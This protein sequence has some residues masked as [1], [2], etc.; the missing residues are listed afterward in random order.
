MKAV[1]LCIFSAT[2]AFAVVAGAADAPRQDTPMLVSQCEGRGGNEAFGAIVQACTAVIESKAYQGKQL[3]TVYLNRANAFDSMGDGHN[4]L[5]DYDKAVE[6]APDIAGTYYN[7]GV[8]YQKSQRDFTAALKDYDCALR[9]DPTY[10][11][12]LFSRA[13]I[14]D[15]QGNDSGAL[16]DYSQA[17]RL[18]PNTAVLLGHRGYDYLR[19]GDYHR[20]LEDENEAIR[21]N[22]KY[23]Q[24]YLYRAVAHGKLGDSAKATQDT[25]TA[26]RLNPSLARNVRINEGKVTDAPQP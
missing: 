1:L 20:A 7:R 8:Y 2:Q 19:Q 25:Q 16:A 12:A 5:I 24:A 13:T 18:S 26:I 21:L 4:A 6:L 11:P 9:I 23:A 10:V 22:P 3:G 17:I 15:A 14:Y